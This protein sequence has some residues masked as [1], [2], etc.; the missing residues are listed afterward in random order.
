MKAQFTI[1]KKVILLFVFPV[2]FLLHKAQYLFPSTSKLKLLLLFY[3]L[4]LVLVAWW[5]TNARSV[6][7]SGRVRPF[8][9]RIVCH[10]QQTDFQLKELFIYSVIIIICKSD[11]KD[12]Q[13]VVKRNEKRRW[14]GMNRRRTRWSFSPLICSLLFFAERVLSRLCFSAPWTVQINE[15]QLLQFLPQ[16]FMIY[17]RLLNGFAINDV[18]VGGDSIIWN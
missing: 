17:Y 15:Q 2:P 6:N 13:W 8:V 5:S 1:N 10:G 16:T 4:L 18:S 7:C 14:C 3:L 11:S 12:Q 9:C